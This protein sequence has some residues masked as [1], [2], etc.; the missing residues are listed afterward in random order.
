[1]YETAI[2]TGK[3]QETM[4]ALPVPG[5]HASLYGSHLLGGR[6]DTIS[7]NNVA[8]VVDGAIPKNTFRGLKLQVH[9]HQASKQFPIIAGI[10]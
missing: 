4:H 3:A 10:S 2:V 8:K 5:W 1:M 6:V 7:V 9:T